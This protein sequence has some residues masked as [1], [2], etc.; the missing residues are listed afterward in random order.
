[1]R[2]AMVIDPAEHGGVA[3]EVAE[4]IRQAAAWLTDAGYIIEEIAP[5]EFGAVIDLWPATGHR[6]FDR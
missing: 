3:P 5:P 1:M 4:A 2:V 6:R